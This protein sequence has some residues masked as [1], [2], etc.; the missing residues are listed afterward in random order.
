MAFARVAGVGG[1]SFVVLLIVGAV[2]LGDQP[3]RD[4]SVEGFQRYLG[5]G[6]CTERPWSSGS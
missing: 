2:L 6:D 3:L 5:E 4:E 1:M